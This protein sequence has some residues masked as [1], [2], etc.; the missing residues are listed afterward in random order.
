MSR[1]LLLA[2]CLTGCSAC[3]SAPDVD[4]GDSAQEVTLAGLLAEMTDRE[5]LARPADPQ[6]TAAMASSYDRRSTARSEPGWF[7]N[8][9]AQQ[10]DATI[11]VNGR[12]EHVLLDVDGPGV[13]TRIW[14]ATPR[15]TL[16]IYLDGS[17]QPVIEEDFTE[18]VSGEV[19]PFV[20]PFAYRVGN[21]GVASC[22][23]DQPD[24]AGNLYFPIPYANGARVT[25]DDRQIFYHVSHRRYAEG[26]S[27][28]TY[29]PRALAAAR[30]ALEAASQALAEPPPP[31]GEA[32]E[33]TL[34]VDADG[35]TVTVEGGDDGGLLTRLSVRVPELDEAALRAT[36]VELAFDRVTTVRAPLPELLGG[37]GPGLASVTSLLATTE[38]R[39]LTL[40][41]V[42]PFRER[43]AVTLRTAGASY[44]AQVSVLV[45]GVDYAEYGRVLNARWMPYRVVPT[46]TPSE[47]TQLEVSGA[48]SYLGNVLDVTNSSR[49]W[50][51]EGDERIYLNGEE[52]PSFFGTGT[53]DY[54]GYA[55]CGATVFTRPYHGQ[56]RVQGPETYGRSS[57]YRWHVLDRIPFTDGLRF[58]LETTHWKTYARVGYEALHLWY[59]AP[60]EAA[61]LDASPLPEIAAHPPEAADR[62]DIPHRWDP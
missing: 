58:D 55:W 10:F 24:G 44:Q 52:F 3:E 8:D 16:R 1:A 51:G 33:E 32:R 4:C 29:G 54:F 14:T 35:A 50:W 38:E 40:D 5:A 19:E 61:A 62:D 6:F 11:T 37:G 20:A 30:C 49:A 18:L 57:L 28:E 39:T 15:G 34:S 9:D 23:P 21:H 7:A 46:A 41:A 27:V 13:I 43:A 42:M 60:T 22:A 25:I 17:E 53:E 31:G 45:R 56:S 59:G 48:G 26:T 47:H 2:L 12:E 36:V